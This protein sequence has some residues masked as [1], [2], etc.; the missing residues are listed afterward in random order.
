M[1]FLAVNYDATTRQDDNE[2][3][4]DDGEDDDNDDDDFFFDSGPEHHWPVWKIIIPA[5]STHSIR[6]RG[7]CT[8]YKQGSHTQ[9]PLPRSIQLPR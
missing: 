2:N 8:S 4:D 3:N 5:D 7:A 9:H 1:S 6:Y